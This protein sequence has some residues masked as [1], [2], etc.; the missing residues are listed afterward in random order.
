MRTAAKGMTLLE[1]VLYI[2]M[3][4]IVLPAMVTF[5]FHLQGQQGMFDARTRMGQS[6]EAVRSV[7]AHTLVSADAV[8]TST[9]TLGANPSTLRLVDVDGVAVVVD[10]PTVSV[11]FPGG[12]VEDVR[13][14]RMQVGAAAPVYL[15]DSD[16]D[17]TSWR[18]DTVRDSANVLTGLRVNLAFAMLAP[19]TSVLR[20]EEFTGTTTYDL[21]PQTLEN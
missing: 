18:V 21:S 16:I 17:V 1:V 2:G 7:L 3:I 6:A 5:V 14:V 12:A 13:R 15:T 20:T 10:C 4:M 19:T 8:R 11:T 9:S